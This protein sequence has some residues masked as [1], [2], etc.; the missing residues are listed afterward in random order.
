MKPI[1]KII[2]QKEESFKSIPWAM[3]AECLPKTQNHIFSPGVYAAPKLQV[4]IP[5]LIWAN[6]FL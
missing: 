2:S 5:D 1:L 3:E 4:W 6:N